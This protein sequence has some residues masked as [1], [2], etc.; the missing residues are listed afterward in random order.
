MF[1]TIDYEQ[2]EGDYVLVD[3][4]S[5]KEYSEFTIP[6]AVNLPIF[7]DEERELI[8]TVYNHESI[9]KAKKMGVDF[10]SK[11][12]LL[13]Y[14]EI[15]KLREEHDKII[16]FCERGGYR[17]SSL[18]ALLNSIGI[19]AVKLRG[20][21][22]GYRAVVNSM[23]PKLN[24]EVN[25]IVIH[26][27]TGTGKTELLKMLENRG[28]DILDL[29][30][31]ANHRG[32]LLGDVGLGSRMSQKQFESLVYDNLRH[33]NS[34]TIFVE[35]ESS[36]I[37]NIV[38]P[39]YIMQSM[40]AGKHILAVGSIE[41]RVRRIVEEYTKGKD[42]DAD[43]INSLEKLGRNISAR[44]IEEYARNIRLGNYHQVAEDLMI[45]YYDPMYENEI[46]EFEYEL[47]VN[48]D[49]IREA[50]LNIEKWLEKARPEYI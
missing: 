37:G 36:R 33:R 26:G 47:T 7:D 42:S 10:A 15:K 22:K 32:S 35:G 21:Y 34:D 25:Y 16:L 41:M 24:S 3:V 14:E 39:H 48:T 13:L 2:L 50:C 43:I 17:S 8:G 31:H 1:N 44:R 9:D 27:Y 20:G 29:E 4:R 49:N 30:K 45:R 6:G 46:K 12:L 40:K 23:L 38:I 18:C 28:Y 11:R 19:G 5:P